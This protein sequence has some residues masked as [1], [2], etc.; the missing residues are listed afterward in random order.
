MFFKKGDCIEISGEL[1]ML[2]FSADEDVFIG[3]EIHASPVFGPVFSN[4]LKLHSN[5]TI[6]YA[7][8]YWIKKVAE[9]SL[10]FE[11][12]LPLTGETHVETESSSSKSNRYER[13]WWIPWVISIASLLIVIA[14]SVPFATLQ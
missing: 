3:R 4:A 11:D 9:P 10:I 12:A 6:H 5:K 2:V 14:K 1:K 7:D 8:K 13:L